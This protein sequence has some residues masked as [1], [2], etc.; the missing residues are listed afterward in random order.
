MPG[1]YI[2]LTI[3]LAVVIMYTTQL[4]SSWKFAQRNSSIFSVVYFGVVGTNTMSS[5]G[6]L[7]KL[8]K[9]FLE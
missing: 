9:F 2:G 5:S 8:G 7:A 1:F 3:L 4:K 6:A